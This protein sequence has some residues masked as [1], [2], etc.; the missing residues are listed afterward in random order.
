MIA[1]HSIMT[2]VSD[3]IIDNSNNSKQMILILGKHNKLEINCT[4]SKPAKRVD[5][6]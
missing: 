5:D 2:Q 4:V 1:V 3:V 6:I